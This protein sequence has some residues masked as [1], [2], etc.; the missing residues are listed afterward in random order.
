MALN[1]EKIIRPHQSLR[2]LVNCN[3]G[4]P[5]G[6]GAVYA[7]RRKGIKADKIA[8]SEF[9]LD[10]IQEFNSDK[11]FYFVG[12]RKE[13]IEQTVDKLKEEFRG[14]K[15][16]GFR[17]GYYEESEYPALL[18]D[19]QQKRPDI[20][21]VA[22]GSPKQEYVMKE[23][24]E[25]HKA[26]YMGLGGSFDVYTRHVQRAPKFW[27]DNHLEWAYRLFKQPKRI[28]RQAH[29]LKFVYLLLMKRL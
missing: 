18:N 16:A 1:A 19:I 20:V 11:T 3:I 7:L 22:L 14:I 8:G 26:L 23:M 28:F 15:I 2:K 21:F 17:D 27:I 29:L 13:V 4:Y 24:Q 10:I 25:R 5:D 12:S 6:V 9:W